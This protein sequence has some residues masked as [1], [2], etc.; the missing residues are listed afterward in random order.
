[1]TRECFF[2]LAKNGLG[3]G[4]TGPNDV[5]R[6][7]SLFSFLSMAVSGLVRGLEWAGGSGVWFLKNVMAGPE[8]VGS[9]WSVGDRCLIGCVLGCWEGTGWA[10]W[11]VS[12][13]SV[14]WTWH[15][16]ITVT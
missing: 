7:F 4:K 10:R 11:G 16:N 14:R 3:N 5:M 2:S 8:E 6:R 12:P 15:S 9:G 13:V 1:M